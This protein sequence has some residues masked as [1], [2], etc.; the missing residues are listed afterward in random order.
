VGLAIGP[1]TV[2]GAGQAQRQSTGTVQTAG[3]GDGQRRGGGPSR[4]QNWWEDANFRKE[5]GLS[6]ATAKRIANIYESRER[7]VMPYLDELTKEGAVLEKMAKERTV[8]GFTF[9]TQAAKVWALRTKLDETRPV[10]IYR[11]SLELTPEQLQ[12]LDQRNRS[13]RPG[14]G[15]SDGGRP[16]WYQDEVFK[17]DLALTDDKSRRITGLYEYRTRQMQPFVEA[18]AAENAVQ[19]KMSQERTAS[20]GAYRV[21]VAKVQALRSRLI[22]SR[23]VMEY[24]MSLELT[25]EQL[26]KIDARDNP[27]GR[28]GGGPR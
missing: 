17:K 18:L 21:Q 5:L 15:G 20:V 25:P 6:D 27:R 26:Q 19:F 24:R 14:G 8:P 23:Q 12:K 1:Q 2:A 16:E 7:D 11:M 9:A 3:R 28:R 10:M 13:R 22:E 4:S